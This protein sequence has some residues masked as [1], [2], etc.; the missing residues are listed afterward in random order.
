MPNWCYNWVTVVT[1]GAVEDRPKVLGAVS[2]L[3]SSEERPFDF[4]RVI[5][6]P[7]GLDEEPGMVGYDWRV[8]NWG[9]KWNVHA[10]E[11]Q[12]DRK[13]DRVEYFFETA[14][15]PP[16]Q[17][18]ERLAERLAE[19]F[20]DLDVTLAYDEPGTDFGGFVYYRDGELE[21]R[22]E[23]GSRMTPWCEVVEERR[24]FG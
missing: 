9:T 7:E 5:P 22:F 16:F 8:D 11:T 1:N 12:V 3:V 18:I 17:V 4:E 14:W 21:D 19:L 24:E 15:S 23:G 10:E 13:A 6:M 20:P 2:S